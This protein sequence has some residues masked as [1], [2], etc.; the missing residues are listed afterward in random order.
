MKIIAIHLL[1]L[2]LISSSCQS[3]NEN[4]DTNFEGDWIAI[5]GLFMDGIILDISPSSLTIIKGLGKK[6]KRFNYKFDQDYLNIGKNSK[7]YI[8]FGKVIDFS[9]DRFKLTTEETDTLE[10]IRLKDINDSQETG[11]IN[12]KNTSWN[13]ILSKMKYRF[14]FYDQLF[15]DKKSSPQKALMHKFGDHPSCKYVYWFLKEY[16]NKQILYISDADYNINVYIIKSANND[17]I[18]LKSFI[19]GVQ[20]DGYLERIHN[21][22]DDKRRE[23]ISLLTS[24][25]WTLTDFDTIQTNEYQLLLQPPQNNSLLKIEDLKN[26]D[27][28][29]EFKKDGKLNY[30]VKDKIF[31]TFYW[32]LSDGG[33][34]IWTESN[35][36]LKCIEIDSIDKDEL[37]INIFETIFIRE[38]NTAPVCKLKLKLK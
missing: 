5:K 3:Q 21:I 10:F 4:N 19:S 25:K 12:L 18:D 7:D 23:I 28:S 29:F 26:K 13:L 33:K 37:R 6:S 22:S 15:F 38:E 32:S 34:Y 14:D 30:I 20:Y 8:P 17:K 9:F 24:K 35:P 27:V 31:K 16:K 2:L 1:L 36:T 11:I